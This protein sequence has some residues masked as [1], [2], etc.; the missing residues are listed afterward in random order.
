M[1]DNMS[2]E[3]DFWNKVERNKALFFVWGIAW[4]P[5]GLVGLVLLKD[6][7]GN[8]SYYGFALLGLW[9]ICW[10]VILIRLKALRCPRCGKQAITHPYFFMK[11]ARCKSCG[12]AYNE[13]A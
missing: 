9:F 4:L 2:A 12:L 13:K 5:M 10:Q 1:L 8:S 7:V 6:A 11:D 3:R